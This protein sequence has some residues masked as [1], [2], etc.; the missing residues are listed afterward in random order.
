MTDKQIKRKAYRILAFGLIFFTL[1]LTFKII[2]DNPK[3]IPKI[4]PIKIEK[5]FQQQHRLN[6]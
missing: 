1:W 3:W 6:A 2:G 4:K 5:P